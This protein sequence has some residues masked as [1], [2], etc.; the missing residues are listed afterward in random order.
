MVSH[1][2]PVHSEFVK[3]MPSTIMLKW[4]KMNPF[5]HHGVVSW[6]KIHNFQKKKRPSLFFL[7]NSGIP[8]VKIHL[9]GES[10]A[11]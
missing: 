3:P 10:N 2:A 8:M 11:Q 4:F 7:I 1:L 5:A 6:E 9:R